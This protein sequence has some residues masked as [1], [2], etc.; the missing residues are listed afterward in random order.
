MP[1]TGQVSGVHIR[2]LMLTIYYLFHI[3]NYKSFQDL[4]HN[5]FDYSRV[6]GCL[7]SIGMPPMQKC[8]SHTIDTGHLHD[9]TKTGNDT[10]TIM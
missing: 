8:R 9:D 2:A 7:I 1:D 10:K 5:I 3:N 4:M 6:G